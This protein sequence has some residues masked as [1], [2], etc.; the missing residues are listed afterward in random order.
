MAGFTLAPDAI[1]KANVAGQGHW[2]LLLDGKLVQPVGTESFTLTG[3]TPGRHVI[4]VELHNN[5]HSLLIPP[6]SRMVNITVA[7][8]PAALPKTGDAGPPPWVLLLAAFAL[9]AGLAI[10][11]LVAIKT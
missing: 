7:A 11:K 10:R 8:A 2:H 5:D 4:A 9:A 3:L 6:V 1:G